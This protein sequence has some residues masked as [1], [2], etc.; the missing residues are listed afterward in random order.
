[1]ARRFEPAI[2]IFCVAKY[3][4]EVMLASGVRSVADYG[5][6]NC[7]EFDLLIVTGGPGWVEQCSCPA[8]TR[9]IKGA[10]EKATVAS[11]CTGAMILAAAGLLDGQAATTRRL[12]APGEAA[13]LSLLNDFAPTAK[14]ETALI[15]DAGVVITGG[16]VTLAI[17]FT[18]Y[19]LE[20][21]FSAELKE[22][23][24]ALMEYDRA[25]AA[26]AEHLAVVR[27]NDGHEAGRRAPAR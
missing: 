14:P 5:F 15:V 20:R 24:A 19:L 27:T 21:F 22:R 17:D 11:V 25:L 1:M 4:G 23:T 7:P 26:N 8:T 16:G 10:Q 18:F 13:P 2:E 6:D 12:S 9:F 3:A